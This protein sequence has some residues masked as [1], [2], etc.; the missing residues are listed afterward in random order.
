MQYPSLKDNDWLAEIVAA[1]FIMSATKTGP[2]EH[3]G[4]SKNSK[5]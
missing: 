1:L 3:K 2:H 4:A 5:F